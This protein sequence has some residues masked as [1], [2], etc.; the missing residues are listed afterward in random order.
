[1]ELPFS[2]SLTKLSMSDVDVDSFICKD[3][4][5]LAVAIKSLVA[6]DI[7]KNFIADEVCFA[8]Y[9]DLLFRT[10]CDTFIGSKRIIR[11]TR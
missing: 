2:K 10:S 8:I 5:D 6:I 4:F 7:S 3:L 1:M 9:L 11:L